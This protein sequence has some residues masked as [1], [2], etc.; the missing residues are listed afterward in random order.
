MSLKNQTNFTQIYTVM[1]VFRIAYLT[2][3][4]IQLRREL[5][6]SAPLSEISI[7][8]DQLLFAVCAAFDLPIE[9]IDQI[10]GTAYNPLP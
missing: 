10:L 9:A 3:S 8:A 1:P 7:P 4:L 6:Q 2:Q 5:E